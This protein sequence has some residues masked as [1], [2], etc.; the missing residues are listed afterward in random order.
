MELF[1]DWVKSYVMLAPYIDALCR[2]N[3]GIS[4]YSVLKRELLPTQTSFEVFLVIQP[5]IEGL[6]KCRLCININ[7]TQCTVNIGV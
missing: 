2:E 5:S 4:S 1:G 7:G 6:D 3:L